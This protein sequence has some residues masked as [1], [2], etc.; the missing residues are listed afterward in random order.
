MQDTE[1]KITGMMIYYY[2]VCRRKLY[3]FTHELRMEQNNE[4]VALGKL[5]DESS[6]SREKE[7]HI[8]IDD[9]ISVD[10]IRK[11]RILHEVKKSRAI[12]EAGVWQLKYYLYY[13]QQRGVTGLRGQI[14]YPQLK[15]T[16][17]VELTEEDCKTLEKML[18]EIQKI[19]NA[20]LP[21]QTFP[22][23]KLCRKC[24]Y[25]DLCYI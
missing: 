11:G 15:Q 20:D 3:Y 9:T 22:S 13:L 5:L 25:F 14:D 10:F 23:R 12:E 19:M 4:E 21:E 6:Y 18:E 16:V 7:K 8:T 17:Q 24:A 1:Q 2:Q